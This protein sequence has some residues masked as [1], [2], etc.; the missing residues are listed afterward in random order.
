MQHNN[1][2]YVQEVKM[3]NLLYYCDPTDIPI[4]EYSYIAES[5]TL[6]DNITCH[7]ESCQLPAI[8]NYQA[9]IIGVPEDR[10]CPIYGSGAAPNVIRYELYQLA[11]I[12]GKLKIID[13]GNLKI[14]NTYNDTIA[15]F[16][17]VLFYLLSRK[18]LPIVIGGNSALSIAF[19]KAM[20]RLERHYVMTA[21]DAHIRYMGDYAVQD[22]L[23]Y[24]YKIIDLQSPYFD[25]FINV[26]YQSYLNDPQVINHLQRKGAELVRVGEVRQ[27]I[28]SVEPLLRDSD[29]ANFSMSAVRQSEAPSAISPSPNGFYGEEIC[30][31]GRYAGISD[32][33]TLFSIMDILCKEGVSSQTASLA[34]QVIW[35]FIEGFSQ[36][37]NE[38]KYL[39]TDT[40]GRFTRHH[41]SIGN[42]GDDL[43]FIQSVSTDRWW[44]EIVDKNGK[45]RYIACS[46]ND[47]YR[48][49]S[50]GEIPDRAVI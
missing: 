39:S 11:K 4:P 1:T 33:I 25:H 29:I 40:S 3:T 43:I 30:L 28:Q 26:G 47:F 6:R 41:V 12:P 24:L 15:G 23:N 16:S 38:T 32:N 22:S 44:I 31:L 35:F 13:L 36:R 8:D 27:S 14:G 48:A 20:Q 17:D 45:K 49:S 7:T 37:Q 34:A 18:I 50:N 10:G 9:A 2:K 21:I 46:Y 5:A 42:D 19:D